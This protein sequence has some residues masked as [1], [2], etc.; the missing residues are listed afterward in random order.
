MELEGFRR[1][2]DII[3]GGGPGMDGPMPTKEELLDAIKKMSNL[4]EES[5]KN[6]MEQI[7]ASAPERP[8]EMEQVAMGSSSLT[9]EIVMLLSLISLVFLVLGEIFLI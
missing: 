9:F 7:L 1:M 2:E 5:R 6:L 8:L 4:D 3:D